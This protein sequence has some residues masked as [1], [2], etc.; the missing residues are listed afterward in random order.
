VASYDLVLDMDDDL[1]SFEAV[2]TIAAAHHRRPRRAA[3]GP[4]RPD[5][6]QGDDRRDEVEHRRAGL[7]LVLTPEAPLPADEPVVVIVDYEGTP[8]ASRLG[9]ARRGGLDR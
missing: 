3:L 2:A 4:G 9:D 1:V 8:G 5:G 7:D 6:D